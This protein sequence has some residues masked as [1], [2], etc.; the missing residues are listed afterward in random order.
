M[1]DAPDRS[2][3]SLHRL[4]TGVL[5]LRVDEA[6]GAPL[7]RVAE[8]INPKRSFLFV[9]TILGRH[10][11]VRPRDHLSA[12]GALVARC[13]GFDLSGPVLVM[14]YAETA[15]GLG[16]AVARCLASAHPAS[17][18][19]YLS[20]T[21]HP[22]PGREWLRFSEGHSHAT[23]HHVLRPDPHPSLVDPRATLI[24]VDDEATTGATFTA[25]LNVLIGAG[26]RFSRILLLTLT[27]W[28]EGAAVAAVRAIAPGSDVHGVSLMR[29]AW[30]WGADPSVT[31]PTLP[32]GGAALTAPWTPENT[33]SPRLGIRD[34]GDGWADLA[35]R[36]PLSRGPVLVIGSGEHVWGPMRLGEELEGRGAD[37]HVLATI[38]SPILQ[39]EVIRDKVTFPDHFGVGVPMYLHNVPSRPD[40]HV[41]VMTETGADRI[42]PVL[43]SHLGRGLVLDGSGHVT[44]FSEK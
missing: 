22:V 13:D 42:C 16:A 10:L 36:L 39:G 25:L 14:G 31:P 3:V 19:L 12:V 26:L 44:E 32:V 37:V 27:D 24:L 38:R 2:P 11:P 7:F 1:L 35:S 6:T 5:T 17:D 43:R 23:D 9:S 18:L 8:R 33:P 41:I 40:A 4:S 15:V 20:T 29:G 21:R 34:W 30:N 28:S